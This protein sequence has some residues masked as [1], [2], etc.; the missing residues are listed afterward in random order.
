MIPGSP[1]FS[2]V[3]ALF[4]AGV[5]ALGAGIALASVLITRKNWQDSN[6]PVVIAYVDEQTSSEGLT[7]FNL[8][9]KNTGN[10]PAVAV[11]LSARSAEIARIVE[12]QTDDNR[13]KNIEAVFTRESSLSVLLPDETVVTSFGLASTQPEEKWLK[14]G[15]EIEAEVNYRDIGRKEYKSYVQLRTRPRKGFGG[16]V[17]RSVA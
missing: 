12:K 15:E 2:A 11:H 5:A 8:Y 7:V 13:R 17:W 3:V 1:E 9:V 14:Y 10:R 16:G 6:R 4:A